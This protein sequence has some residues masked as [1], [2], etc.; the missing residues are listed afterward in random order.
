MIVDEEIEVKQTEINFD[1]LRDSKTLLQ[2]ENYDWI[3]KETLVVII[4]AQGGLPLDF[5][6]S[7]KN[8]LQW[9][10]LATSGCQQKIVEQPSD[11]EFL[12]KIRA[13]SEGFDFVAVFYSDTPLLKKSTFFDIMTYFSKHKM[14]VLKL[15]RGFVFRGEYLKTAKM[16]LSSNVEKFDEEDFTVVNSS[17]TASYAF[18]VLNKRIL[19]YHKANGVTFFGE[20]TIFIDADVEIEAGT[21]IHPNNVLKGET[22]IGKN[23]VLECGNQITDTIVCDGAVVCQSYLQNCKIEEKKKV[24]PF[25]KIIGKN[26]R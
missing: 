21:V 8:T 10:Q 23:V 7:G 5:L 15:S 11:D 2:P 18:E 24:G 20:N 1:F 22:Y 12:E 26:Y 13:L 4:K 6:I 9:V 14:N 25:E 16:L 19:E 3:S 17:S